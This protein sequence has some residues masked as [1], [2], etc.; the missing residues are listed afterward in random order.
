MLEFK[1]QYY[2]EEYKESNII[3]YTKFKEDFKKKHKD[4]ILLKELYIMI[5][6]YQINNYTI[7]LGSGKDVTRNVKTGTYS[8]LERSRNYVRFGSNE[9]R[10]ARKVRDKYK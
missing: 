7:L 10:N 4:F 5:Q 3:S 2:F 6:K 8:K 1:L 9:E